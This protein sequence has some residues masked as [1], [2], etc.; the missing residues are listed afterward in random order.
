MVQKSKAS[1]VVCAF[2]IQTGGDNEFSV[3][4][5]IGAIVG[6]ILTGEIYQS[7]YERVEHKQPGRSLSDDVKDEWE[8]IKGQA[9]HREVFDP[10]IPRKD[11]TL[12][13]KLFNRFVLDNSGEDNPVGGVVHL[14]STQSESQTSLL[15]HAMRQCNVEP[16]WQAR[17]QD[18]LATLDYTYRLVFSEDPMESNPFVGTKK[19][20]KFE[21]KHVFKTAHVIMRRLNEKMDLSAIL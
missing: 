12:V 11:L 6:N 3:I 20:A 21:A 4:Y 7:F 14:L 5:S 15:L 17:Y 1:P 9:A 13:L 19:H 16:S 8:K 10:K 18:S 2:N